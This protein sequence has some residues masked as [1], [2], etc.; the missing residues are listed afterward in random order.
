MAVNK[1]AIIRYHALDKCFRNKHRRY[2][3]EDLIAAV[4]DEL[5]EILG[6]GHEVKRRQ[7][8]NDIQYMESPQGWSIPLERIPDGKTCFYRYSENFSI[9]QR[10]LD[11]DE[12]NTL[13]QAVSMLN[14]FKG[15]PQF[16]WIESMLANLQDKFQ[17]KGNQDPVI[18]FEQN[19]DYLAAT[20]LADLFN[21]IINRQ[22]LYLKYKTFSDKELEWTLH[23]YYIKQYNNR[24]FLFGRDNNR[25]ENIIN[26]ALDR[27]LSFQAVNI[28]YI[29]SDINFDEYFDDIIGVSHP[30]KGK[31]ERVV[32][33]FDAE[34]FPYV[35][36]KPLHGSMRILDRD[37]GVVSLDLIPNKELEARIFSFGNQVEVLEPQ[38]LREQ[39]KEKIETLMKKYSS[40]ADILHR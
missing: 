9:N 11:D 2:Y 24:W 30:N 6:P 26:I 33:R 15:M 10:P 36:S 13:A 27:I 19:I 12:M 35:E 29:D 20:H 7:I 28:P 1:Y 39:I 32:L 17:M 8:Y 40:S 25:T 22:V 3:M 38:W 23:P 5:Y 18:G 21:A 37:N 31:E 16:E 34:R 14:R 4:N